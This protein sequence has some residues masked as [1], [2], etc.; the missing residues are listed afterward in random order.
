[1]AGIG[2]DAAGR[3]VYGENEAADFGLVYQLASNITVAANAGTTSTAAVRGGS[4]IFDAQFTGTSIVLQALGADGTTYRN[5]ATLSASGS[6]GVVLGANSTVRLY[7]PNG[8]ADTGVY[9][10]LS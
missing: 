7:N 9:A 10:S 1:M 3:E 6:T 8:A 5:V 2:R 4:Y